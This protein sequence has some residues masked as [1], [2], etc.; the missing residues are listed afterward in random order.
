M[1]EEDRGK[2]LIL[3]IKQQIPRFQRR[4]PPLQSR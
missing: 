2:D 3:S 4:G 1:D